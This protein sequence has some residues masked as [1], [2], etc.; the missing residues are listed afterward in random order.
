MSWKLTSNCASTLAPLR[1]S[2]PEKNEGRCTDSKDAD[3][4]FFE[5][6][7]DAWLWRP[8]NRPLSIDTAASR[9]TG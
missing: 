6:G 7:T 1:D 2:E 3:S 9:K 8:A 5:I 4:R